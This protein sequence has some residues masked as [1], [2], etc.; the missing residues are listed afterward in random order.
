MTLLNHQ[1]SQPFA[2]RLSEFAPHSKYA[3][4]LPVGVAFLTCLSCCF[5]LSLSFIN[6]SSQLHK[7]LRMASSDQEEADFSSSPLPNDVLF[8][9]PDPSKW[10]SSHK[11]AFSNIE[12]KKTTTF[13]SFTKA[14]TATSA[15]A[16]ESTPFLFNPRE[17]AL[18][19]Q[20]KNIATSAAL[21]IE[22]EQ[23]EAGWRLALDPLIFNQFVTQSSWSVASL[24]IFPS[25][26]RYSQKCYPRNLFSRSLP[27]ADD[28]SITST[29]CPFPGNEDSKSRFVIAFSLQFSDQANFTSSSKDSSSKQFSARINQKIVD[30]ENTSERFGCPQRCQGLRAI[31]DLNPILD[32]WRGSSHIQIGSK[33]NLRMSPMDPE[34]KPLLF[35]FLIHQTKSK[36]SQYT[37]QSIRQETAAS[38][39][40]IL[41]I[42]KDLKVAN[43]EMSKWQ[44]GPLVWIVM[45][46]EETWRVSAGYHDENHE[47]YVS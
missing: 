7:R 40:A 1:L 30:E 25:I 34:H 5:I 31:E 8:D 4:L 3:D 42:Q 43:Q 27:I 13:C 32:N 45:S 37:V 17:A 10:P 23:N 47:C 6:I 11:D 41:R 20:A 36:G 18:I 12:E 29:R 16:E 38:I 24:L 22:E 39:H 44:Q 19:K 46:N 33:N 15:F 28:P 35:P 21:C 26:D 2:R 14:Y 9:G